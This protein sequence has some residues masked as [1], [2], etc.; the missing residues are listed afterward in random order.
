MRKKD[1]SAKNK[2]IIKT[3]A[4]TDTVYQGKTG[5][6]TGAH[7]YGVWVHTPRPP[8]VVFTR[9][10]STGREKPSMDRRK[11]NIQCEV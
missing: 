2:D 10:S 11:S 1:N 7:L 3:M 4:V 9:K 6:R 5:V 8:V